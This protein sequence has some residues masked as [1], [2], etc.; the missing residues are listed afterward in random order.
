M[1]YNYTLSVFLDYTVSLYVTR[2]PTLYPKQTFCARTALS[3]V[4]TCRV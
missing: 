4:I 2:K 1:S 3:C